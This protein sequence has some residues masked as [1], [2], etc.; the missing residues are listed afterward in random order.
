[1]VAAHKLEMAMSLWL[2]LHNLVVPTLL[3]LL[4]GLVFMVP[5]LYASVGFGGSS[6]YMVV[7]SF[8]DIPSTVASSTALSFNVIDRELPSSITLIMDIYR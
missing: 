1:M 2:A 4:A 8:F 7:T 6:G 3:P 5:F